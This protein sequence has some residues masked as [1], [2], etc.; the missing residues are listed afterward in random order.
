[1]GEEMGQE[2]CVVCA[3]AAVED[4]ERGTLA[5]FVVVDEYAV[6]IDVALLGG[7]GGGRGLRGGEWRGDQHG[8]GEQEGSAQSF[9][10]LMLRQGGR[11]LQENLQV[12]GG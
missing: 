3:R 1:M 9:H 10:G 11:E 12:G 8:K 5:E 4:D 2:V 7:V 6:G